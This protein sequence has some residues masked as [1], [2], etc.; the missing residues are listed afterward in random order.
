MKYQKFSIICFSIIEIISCSHNSNASTPLPTQ[1]Q[2]S[3]TCT[4]PISSIPFCSSLQNDTQGTTCEIAIQNLLPAQSAVGE[5][6]IKYKLGSLNDIAAKDPAN[7]VI[8][9][10]NVTQNTS[11]MVPVTYVQ[12]QF[13]IADKHHFLR[14][15]SEFNQAH[16][17][18][19]CVI[20]Q[21]QNSLPGVSF[22]N[23]ADFWNMMS[24]FNLAYL[25]QGTDN[26]PLYP[27]TSVAQMPDDVFR[28][29]AGY[30]PLYTFTNASGK[31]Q[32]IIG[33]SEELFVQFKWAKALQNE[34]AKLNPPIALTQENFY[35]QTI[36]GAPITPP[37]VQTVMNNP[38]LITADA[39]VV[40]D[41]YLTQIINDDAD[42][43]IITAVN[44]LVAQ[45]VLPAPSAQ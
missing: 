28:S 35:T 16:N 21:I 3:T 7:E 17:Q 15:L 37:M 26:S 25:E 40:L 10:S 33:N 23:S 14:S 22:D 19:F 27:T 9:I 29:L 34:L 30:L 38:N 6:E 45:K 32:H 4:N 24:N 12:G 39:V 41:G 2:N 8:N 1:L 11:N 43:K 42:Y 13:Y 31:K 20:V 18:N 36:A 5:L 44:N